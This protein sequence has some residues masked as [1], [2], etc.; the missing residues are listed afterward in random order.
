M[1]RQPGLGDFRDDAALQR[2]LAGLRIR[3]LEH[4]V[5]QRPKTPRQRNII[6]VVISL[7]RLHLGDL[8]R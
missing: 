1:Q 5:M 3:R 4:R 7:K 2:E 6:D 8:W